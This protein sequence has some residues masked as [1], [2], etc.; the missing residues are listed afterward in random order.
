MGYGNAITG[1]KQAQT[2]GSNRVRKARKV[3]QK[4]TWRQRLR[5]W[6]NKDIDEPEECFVQDIEPAR[7]DSEGMRLQIYKA[8][9]GYVV[10]TRYYDRH[11]DRNFNT[12]HVITED[13]DLGN[14]L[15]KIV[16]MEALQR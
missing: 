13:Q 11:K 14:A 8:S 12:M 2:L 15:G 10:E 6:L 4:T 5:N 16:M 7:L 1:A 9:G 3:K